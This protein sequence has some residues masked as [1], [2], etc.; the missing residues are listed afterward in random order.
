[1]T[2]SF[3]TQPDRGLFTDFP[4][5]LFKVRRDAGRRSTNPPE[6]FD[7]IG[8]AKFIFLQTF[9][10][11]ALVMPT[12]FLVSRFFYNYLKVAQALDPNAIFWFITILACAET[13]AFR[14]IMVV[15]ISAMM[16]RV[17]DAQ[18]QIERLAD[19]DALTGLEKMAERLI[20]AAA[21]GLG[22]EFKRPGRPA[23]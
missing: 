4:Q 5:P 15:P 1:V 20:A 12:T 10:A 7:V 8:V 11:L 9:A 3:V 18:A 22:R 17:R 2:Q 23:A 6:R 14:P 19:T 13:V 16:R 21:A